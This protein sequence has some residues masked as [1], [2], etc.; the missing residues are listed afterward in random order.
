MDE[1]IRDIR[2][3]ELLLDSSVGCES[4][5]FTVRSG[6]FLKYYFDRF[7]VNFTHAFKDFTTSEINN[8][9]VRYESTLKNMFNDPLMIFDK[10]LVPI[11][12]GMV[13]S[14]RDTLVD[15]NEMRHR[16]SSDFILDHLSNVLTDTLEGPFYT[17]ISFEKD[18]E[19]I[20]SLFSKIG[21]IHSLSEVV[22]ESRENL[23]FSND[24]LQKITSSD[25][26]IVL[27]IIPKLKEIEN[28]HEK[29][30]VSKE[31]K[32]RLN[33]ILMSMAYRLSMFGI[34]MDHV[35][36]TEH[37]FVKCLDILRRKSLRNM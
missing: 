10:E 22:L 15:L 32:E 1:I 35:Q 19:I 29:L 31:E 2:R 27:S 8:Y 7:L 20:G 33:K 14:Y 24:T 18:K 17:K 3:L 26:P 25:Y 37:N 12:K 13:K 9:N 16:I 28:N 23:K 34:I 4:I 36:S 30:I 21:L 5:S 11:P 6:D